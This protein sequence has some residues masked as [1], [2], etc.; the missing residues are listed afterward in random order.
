MYL[1]LVLPVVSLLLLSVVLARV[2][3]LLG[4]PP[5]PA[6]LHKMEDV[7]YCSP[8]ISSVTYDSVHMAARLSEVILLIC[9]RK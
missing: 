7:S 1:L 9:N 2:A 5:G 6:K 3:V 8:I 4:V